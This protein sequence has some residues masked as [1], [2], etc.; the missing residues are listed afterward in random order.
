MSQF[1]F[2]LA[3]PTS[4]CLSISLSPMARRAFIAGSLC[5]LLLFTPSYTLLEKRIVTQNTVSLLCS[6]HTAGSTQT[7]CGNN[8]KKQPEIHKRQSQQMKVSYCTSWVHRPS[9]LY[10]Q[11]QMSFALHPQNEFFFESHNEEFLVCLFY[12]RSDKQGKEKLVIELNVN[13]Q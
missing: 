11:L 12:S 10:S 9:H 5:L 7:A 6:F 1:Y 4:L 3:L 13:T 2:P 8:R